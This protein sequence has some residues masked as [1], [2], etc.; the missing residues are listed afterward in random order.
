MKNTMTFLKLGL[1][2]AWLASSLACGATQNKNAGN[3]SNVRADNLNSNTSVKSENSNA[4]NN[5]ASETKVNNRDPQ[6]FC[7]IMSDFVN[8]E[9]T[10]GAVNYKCS[11]KKSLNLESGRTQDFFFDAEGDA[12]NV[13]TIRLSFV[14]KTEFKDNAKVDEEFLKA[15]EQL[16]F[17][18]FTMPLPE[19]IGKMILSAK[20]KASEQN[21]TFTVPTD[22]EFKSVKTFTE[23]TR[24]TFLR[25]R[26]S[27]D[28][29]G[30][31]FDFELP[32]K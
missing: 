4:T 19:D 17:A 30:V 31:S 3:S 14:T 7:N 13:K 8:G 25:H 15:C 18:V 27:A 2:S 21:K 20:G 1:I 9:Y 28:R 32:A 6:R 24:A 11:G 12:E 23:P 10:Q 29:Y 5:A 22:A 26:T 16:W